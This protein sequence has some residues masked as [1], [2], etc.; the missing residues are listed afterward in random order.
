VW[1][2]YDGDRRLDLVT[3]GEWMPIE[4]YRNDGARLVHATA[5][6]KLPPTRGWW[7][8]LAAGDFDGDGRPDL[9]AGNL[10]LNH[11]YRTSSASRFGVYAADLT[12]NG[13]LDIV[14]T[15]SVGGVEYPLGGFA[16]LGRAVYTLGAKF[17]TAGSFAQAPLAKLLGPNDLKD[18]VHYEADTF[19]SVYLRNAGGGTFRAETLPDLAQIAPIRG[20]VVD[21]VDGDGHLDA[22][23]AGNVYDT[24]PYT[25]RADAGNGLWLRG[26]GKGRF[27][28]VPPVESGFLAPGNVSGLALAG[29]PAGR[30][31][32][33]ANTADSMQAFRIAR[34]QRVLAAAARE[35]H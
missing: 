5:A 8:S 33:V 17:P 22:V 19:A 6:T 20:I 14:F 26:D 18:A 31:V 23:V 3:T 25:P 4:F 21:D 16:S 35:K 2:D 27:V 1:I 34:T 13:T 15:Q 9:L 29:S 10:G 12:R 28:A 30:T 11:T 32:L 24:E 7:F